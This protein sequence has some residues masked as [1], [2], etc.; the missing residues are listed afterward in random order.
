M[1]KVKITD[2]VGTI[3]L[4]RPDKCNAINRQLV[5]ELRQAFD[6]LHQERRVRGIVLTGAG[7][8]FCAG[9]DAG[10]LH[11]TSTAEDA[12]QRWFEDAKALQELLQQML[13]CPK[14]IVAAVDGFAIG[15]GFALVLASDLVI[16]THRTQFSVPSTKLGIVSGLT[17]P[18]L[19]FR[20][21]ASLAS[22]IL[23][24]GNVLKAADAKD[25]S[26]VHHVVDPDKLW[27]RASS[28][29][30]EIAEG[31]AESLQLT[32]KVL[33]EMVGEQLQT[34][35]SSGAAA[36]ATSL[37]TEAAAEGLS[38]FTDKRSPD[39]PS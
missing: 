36:T 23:I 35:L 2:S 14:P 38:A 3:I 39:F 26:L 5:Q 30:E 18:L 37:T 8:H 7:N 34:Q 28:W 19:T 16:G 31:A 17:I 29:L 6:D 1:L 9:L 10:E 24:G 15:Y 22:Q 27:V 33:N 13:N 20:L 12:M 21:G 11:S 25:M 32:K 4:D